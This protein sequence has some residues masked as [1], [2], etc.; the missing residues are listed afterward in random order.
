M[1]C[2]LIP[3]K[4]NAKSERQSLALVGQYDLWVRKGAVSVLGAVI[5]S[6]STLHRVFAPSSHSLPCIRHV[7]NP[8]GP[9]NQPAE[10]SVISCSTRIRLLRRLSKKFKRIWNAPQ[11]NIIYRSFRFVRVIYKSIINKLISPVASKLR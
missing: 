3:S 7:Q 11:Q 10:I 8:Y 1:L 2:S 9:S 5:H 4:C 6:S